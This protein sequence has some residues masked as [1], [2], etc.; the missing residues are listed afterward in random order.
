MVERT[1]YGWC[2]GQPKQGN[3]GNRPAGSRRDRS[4]RTIRLDATQRLRKRTLIWRWLT[5]NDVSR[6]FRLSLLSTTWA[7]VMPERSSTTRLSSS[8]SIVGTGLRPFSPFFAKR[9]SRGKATL[10]DAVAA[11]KLVDEVIGSSLFA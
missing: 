1:R 8:N 5:G 2:L 10:D 4:P 6:S 11:A 9:P 3:D 7:G